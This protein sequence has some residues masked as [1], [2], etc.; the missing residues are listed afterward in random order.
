MQQDPLMK[1]LAAYGADVEGICDRFMDDMDLYRMCFSSFLTDGGFETLAR[2]LE[3]K[4][5]EAAFH[6]AHALKGVAGN[7]GLIPLYHAICEL[8]ESLRGRHLDSIDAQYAV[9]Q[10]Q[11]A[12]VKALSE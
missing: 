2:A 5:Y 8:V 10:K 7:I 12:I 4:D 1:K 6:A 11:Y 3:K 9:V